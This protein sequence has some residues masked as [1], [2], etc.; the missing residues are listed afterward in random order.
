MSSGLH[1]AAQAAQGLNPNGKPCGVPGVAQGVPCPGPS[2]P[3]VT[4]HIA[5]DH[6][7]GTVNNYTTRGSRGEPAAEPAG[8]ADKCFHCAGRGPSMPAHQL[9]AR[10]V[11]WSSASNLLA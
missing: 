10:G 3:T 5:G 9:C 2:A 8:N 11:G 6:N 4:Y 7:T 1:R